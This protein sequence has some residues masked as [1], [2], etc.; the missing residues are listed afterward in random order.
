MARVGVGYWVLGATA[1][2]RPFSNTFNPI[3]LLPQH[4]IPN[5]YDGRDRTRTRN[6]RFWKPLLYQLSY[7]PTIHAIQ[8]ATAPENLSGAGPVFTIRTIRYPGGSGDRT[9]DPLL[10][11]QRSTRQ[12]KS[13]IS[14]WRTPVIKPR[15]G[16]VVFR[17]ITATLSLHGDDL[18]RDCVETSNLVS[19][20]RK[21]SPRNRVFAPLVS[22]HSGEGRNYHGD[23]HA[24]RGTLG[25]ENREGDERQK[26][27][28]S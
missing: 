28:F 7:S 13:C 2:P 9:G 8:N 27:L 5:T 10:N 18:L 25:H 3:P 17:I 20:S 19:S 21:D 1:L 22:R 16:I 12:P 11:Q 14:A 26:H 24:A 4:P 23:S 6:T 15:T